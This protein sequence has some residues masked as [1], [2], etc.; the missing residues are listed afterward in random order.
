MFN[1]NWNTNPNIT[2]IEADGLVEFSYWIKEAA[3]KIISLQDLEKYIY[4]RTYENPRSSFYQKS[5][6]E[7]FEALS[8]VIERCFNM[9]TLLSVLKSAQ[10]DYDLERDRH[11]NELDSES[12]EYKN[13]VDITVEFEL[14]SEIEATSE[15]KPLSKSDGSLDLRALDLY[16][17]FIINALSVFDYH[18]F[19]VLE[20]HQSS[21]SYSYY[22]TL[23]KKDYAKNKDYKYILFIRLSDHTNRSESEK[24]RKAFYA[25]EA[26]RLKEPKTKTK[27]I[28]R[29]KEIT[30][31]N[32]TYFS[33][34]DALED[35]DKRLN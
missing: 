31:N 35:L 5:P 16:D 4:S 14:L 13:K 19:E 21:S 34:E 6:S 25:K 12:K 11:F 20:E 3:K 10:K 2:Q 15:I 23:V 30:I 22:F 17:E 32:E 18:D 1:D 28:W 33:Y 27:Q 8:K 29:L 7:R 24:A 26:D 9:N